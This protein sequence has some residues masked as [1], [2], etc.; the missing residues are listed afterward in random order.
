[1]AREG[2]YIG[3]LSTNV[4]FLISKAIQ[5]G[6]F[7]KDFLCYVQVHIVY[8]GERPQGDFSVASTHHSMLAR[9]LGR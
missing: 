6:F 2:R 5:L 7:I 1:M 3:F 8:M 9:V 4:V